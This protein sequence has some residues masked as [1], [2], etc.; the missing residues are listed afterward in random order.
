VL[1]VDSEVRAVRIAGEEDVSHCQL[2]L[3]NA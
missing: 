1:E 2:L 3:R